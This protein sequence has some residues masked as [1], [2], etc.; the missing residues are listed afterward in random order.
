MQKLPCLF[1]G[2]NESRI[3]RVSQGLILCWKHF[4]KVLRGLVTASLS[5][6]EFP[7]QV[8]Q[9]LKS[10]KFLMMAMFIMRFGLF[11]HRLSF[12]L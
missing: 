7:R 6:H 10:R 2:W 9:T 4:R 12:Y 8:V 1:S 5:G 11:K 3:M